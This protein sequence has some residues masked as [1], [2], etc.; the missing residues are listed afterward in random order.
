MYFQ[1][2]RGSLRCSIY[3]YENVVFGKQF[4][5]LPIGI[6]TTDLYYLFSCLAVGLLFHLITGN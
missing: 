5:L 3:L 6:K 2:Y 1:T 4:M